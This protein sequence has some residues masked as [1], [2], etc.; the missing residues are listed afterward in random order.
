MSIMPRPCRYPARRA[1]QA[2]TSSRNRGARRKTAWGTSIP[3]I[4]SGSCPLYSPYEPSQ[5]IRNWAISSLLSSMFIKC[6]LPLKP[7]SCSRTKSF[8]T[9]ACSM[10]WC[11]HT[12]VCV[13]AD[14]WDTMTMVGIPCRFSSLCTGAPCRQQ[15]ASFGPA[16]ALFGR[17][18]SWIGD[19]RRISN[20]LVGDAP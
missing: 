1:S 18:T 16:G 10:Y 11:M 17:R 15:V 5:S 13:G 2:A 20:R 7:T 3:S 14:D 8:L 12:C 6:P 19:W 4:P 9:P